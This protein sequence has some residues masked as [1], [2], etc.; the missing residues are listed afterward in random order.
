VPDYLAT[1]GEFHVG[2]T[3][4]IHTLEVQDSGAINIGKSAIRGKNVSPCT[5]Y[6][7]L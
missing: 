1:L 6:I 7:S 5:R 2:F 4:C 3:G